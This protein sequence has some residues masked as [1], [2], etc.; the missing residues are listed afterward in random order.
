MLSLALISLFLLYGTV[1]HEVDAMVPMSNA[2]TKDLIVNLGEDE[3]TL[4]FN[5]CCDSKISGI[6]TVKVLE[7][8]KT[9]TGLQ[10]MVDESTRYNKVTVTG[11][12]PDMVYKCQISSD[13]VNYS[14]TYSIMTS[15]S[16]NF[17]FAAVGDP[18]I[19]ASSNSY[20]DSVNWKV[21]VDEIADKGAY[22]IVGVGDQIDYQGGESDLSLL[23]Q[24]YSG[25]INGLTHESRLMPYAVTIGNHEGYRA[26]WFG[27]EM[28]NYHYFFPNKSMRITMYDFELV[29]YYYV[30]NNTLFV[31]LDTAPYPNPADTVFIKSLINEYDH[32]LSVATTEFENMYD[33]LVVQTHKSVQCNPANYVV[34]DIE[35]YS[36]GGFEDLMT[37]YDVDLVLAGHTHSYIRTYP[38]KSNATTIGTGGPMIPDGISI[39][40]NNTCNEMINPDGTIYMLLNSASGSEYYDINSSRKFTSKIEIQ[41]YTPQ[42]TM[43]NIS[44]LQMTVDTFEVGSPTVVDHFE[45]TKTQ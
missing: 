5:W 28:F 29:N 35:A 21:T 32:T 23:K 14:E 27:R 12:S 10:G 42:Y 18:Q 6:P 33:W 24:Q 22:F 8:Q 39:D 43:I 16:N 36:R 44:D 45:I 11:L 37:K 13:G 34:E 9:Y 31:V 1:N 20:I 3:S 41:N 40:A 7:T 38:F 26:M 17:T 15:N 19:G 4:N 2:H 25:F 30:Y